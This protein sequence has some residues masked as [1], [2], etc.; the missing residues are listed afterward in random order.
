MGKQ[1]DKYKFYSMGLS[2]KSVFFLQTYLDIKNNKKNIN[3]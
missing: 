1:R 2:I 3:V